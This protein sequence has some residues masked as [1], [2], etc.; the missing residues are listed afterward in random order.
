[1]LNNIQFSVKNGG[2]GQI[3]PNEDNISALM[4]AVASL[5]VAWPASK[6]ASF[7][8]IEDVQTAGILEGHAVFGEVW[9]QAKEYFR[10]SPGATLWLGLGTSVPT[11]LELLAATGGRV[12]QVGVYF[13][14]F[15]DLG[16]VHQAGALALQAQEAPLVVIAGY[17]P[18]AAITVASLQDLTA[19]TPAPL[20]SVVCVGDGGGRGSALAA[21]LTLPYIPC[22]GAV[23]GAVSKASVHEDIAW[24]EKFIMSNG[25]EL[26]KVQ[27]PDGSKNPTLSVIEGL[28]TKRYIVLRGFSDYPGTY[29]NDSHN[30][31]LVA[32]NDYAYIERNRTL[33]KAR[34]MTYKALLADLNSPIAVDP[35]TGKVAAGT[36]SYFLAK[37]DRLVFAPLFSAGEI[38][39]G[40]AYI[41]PNQNVLANSCLQ[42]S[43]RIVPRG[44]ARE[45]KVD[46]GYA[47]TV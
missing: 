14:N 15:S 13:S 17:R 18:T 46:I 9:Y 3:A 4:V 22:L 31:S 10:L 25:L 36:I 12:R 8:A 23:L 47:V 6:F 5:P 27:L 35:S 32:N 1:M 2:L 20:V 21:A 11:Y 37:I 34:R 45:I 24:V 38:S 39:G 40:K 28:N 41:N 42:I 26:E 19:L 7:N 29:L 30:V 43:L 16:A 33:Q 44:V